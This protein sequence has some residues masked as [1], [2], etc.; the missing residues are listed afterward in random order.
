MKFGWPKLPRHFCDYAGNFGHFYIE[1]PI[2]KKLSFTEVFSEF[3]SAIPPL[4][5]NGGQSYPDPR[6]T[7]ATSFK[8]HFK[9][10]NATFPQSVCTIRKRGLK[11]V[12][13][14]FSHE[15]RPIFL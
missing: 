9:I 3:S 1:K 13:G 6:V 2:R 11:G 10:F 12:N 15:K 5:K 8:N 14:F 4:E 7:L